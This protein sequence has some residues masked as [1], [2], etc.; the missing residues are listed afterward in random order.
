[1]ESASEAEL[2][3]L[4]ITEKTMIP[5]RNNL[6]E[7]GWPQPKLPIQTDNSMTVGFTYN[8]II[9]SA[10]FN[11]TNGKDNSGIIVRQ[12]LKK[13]VITAQSITL[14]YIMKRREL[15]HILCKSP[16]PF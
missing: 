3:A 8:A 9:N 1:M 13:R 7:M 5:L 16:P 11:T 4:Y 2:A 6:I 10:R 14:R 15:T 12:D